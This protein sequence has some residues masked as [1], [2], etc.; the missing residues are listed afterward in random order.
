MEVNYVYVPVETMMDIDIIHC[1]E[2][3]DRKAENIYIVDEQ[4]DYTG[5]AVVVKEMV[6]LWENDF[7]CVVEIPGVDKENMK[8]VWHKYHHFDEIPVVQG[9]KIVAVISKNIQEKVECK[10]RGG[11]SLL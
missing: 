10:P 6:R 1:I 11:R 8:D 3:A 5:K 4:G 9:K 2:A 7:S